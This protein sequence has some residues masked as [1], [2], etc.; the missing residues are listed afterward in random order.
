MYTTYPKVAM[1]RNTRKHRVGLL[2]VSVGTT[3]VLVMFGF[4]KFRRLAH[5]TESGVLTIFLALVF[6]WTCAKLTRSPSVFDS[7][8]GKVFRISSE[9]GVYFTGSLFGMKM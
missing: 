7:L 9:S 6:F 2:T 4:I 1:I 8:T 3:S 5:H